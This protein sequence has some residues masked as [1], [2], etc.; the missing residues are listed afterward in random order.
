MDSGTRGEDGLKE[1]PRWKTSVV[2]PFLQGNSKGRGGAAL[3]TFRLREEKSK[4]ACTKEEKAP[5]GLGNTDRRDHR[6]RALLMSEKD[7]GDHFQRH[8]KPNYR[9]QLGTNSKKHSEH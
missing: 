9:V 2:V 6:K 7:R 5:T 1:L 4:G 3:S 8:K